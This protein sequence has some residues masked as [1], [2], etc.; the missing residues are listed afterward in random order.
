MKSKRF[1]SLVLVS[2]CLIS[3]NKEDNDIFKDVFD[4]P[5]TIISLTRNGARYYLHN[6]QTELLN[7]NAIYCKTTSETYE[8]DFQKDS[9]TSY[10]APIYEKLLYF[11]DCV[12]ET[13]KTNKE[14]ATFN[15]T[16]NAILGKTADVIDEETYYYLTKK[17][18]EENSKEYVLNKIN[19]NK[20]TNEI[21]EEIIKEDTTDSQLFYMKNYMCS[22]LLKNYAEYYSSIFETHDYFYMNE[23]LDT[24]YD[25][26]HNSTVK[27]LENETN[28]GTSDEVNKVP[29]LI[30]K[31][32]YIKHKF[33]G[34]VWRLSSYAVSKK[35]YQLED[36]NGNFL[37]EA[38]LIS[39]EEKMSVFSYE[40]NGNCE[41]IRT[42][43]ADK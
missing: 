41:S 11:E 3:C 40:S 36:C 23:K 8:N 39:K 35:T 7:L 43:T 42:V 30:E 34:K 13:T 18:S 1:L 27:R 24:L 10:V 5:Q 20:I 26:R 9:K 19:K 21:E 38:K 4:V 33:D 25:V 6:S 29:V 22:K 2:L 31:D 37:S 28:K 32:T 14:N 16:K 15:K 12:I 17:N